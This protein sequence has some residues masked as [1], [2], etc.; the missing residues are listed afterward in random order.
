MKKRLLSG[1]LA[2]T[3]C[4]SMT[5][6]IAW[7]S[8]M[9]EF[10]DGG[11]SGESEKKEEF[12]DEP[13]IEEEKEQPATTAGVPEVENGFSDGILDAAQDTSA[14]TKHTVKIDTSP[15][16]KIGTDTIYDV[17]NNHD[18]TLTVGEDPEIIA[19]SGELSKG[20]S[21]KYKSQN[22]I[23]PYAQYHSK[24]PESN[25][26]RYYGINKLN[27]IPK[28]RKINITNIYTLFCVV[29]GHL[30]GDILANY[31]GVENP[32][33]VNYGLQGG[34]GGPNRDWVWNG[35]GQWNTDHNIEPTKAGYKF[36]GW[37]T[38]ANGNG[39]KIE[40]VSQAVNAAVAGSN[41]YKEITLYAKWVH[42]HA[43]NYSLSGDTLK[44]Y[45]SNTTS[46][47]DYYGT[48]FDNAKATVS[49]KLNGFD[50]NNCA[51]YGNSYSVTCAN[52]LP[53]EIGAT[54]GSII[55]AGR[56]GTTFSESETLPTSPGKYKAKVNITLPGEQYSGEISTDFEIKK[57]PV[58][59]T[60]FLDDFTYG[61]QPAIQI[62][63]APSDSKVVYQYKVK[64]EDDSTYAGITEE[65]LKKLSAGE[66]TL[67]AVVEET[68]NY[69]GDSDTCIFKVKKAST[70]NSD[71]K[72][73]ISGWT[74]GGYNGVENTPSI[75]S[76]L[77][78][79]NQT[80]QYTYYTD[81]ACSTQTSTKNGAETEGGV[82][83]NAGTY[84]V[85]A[86]IPESA[87]YN[88][89]TATGTFE[90]KP[91]PAQLDWSSSD[92]TYNG[93]DQTVTARVRNALPGDTF[94]LTYE[95]NET[96][97]NTGKNARKYTAKVT[98]LGNTNYSLS[99]EES[100]YSWEIK[101]ASTTN[102]ASKVSINGWTYGGYN[103]A[104]NTPSID[105]SLNPENQTVQ[106]TYYTDGACSTQTS[107]KNGAETEGGVPKN[108]GTYYVKAQIPESANYN[109]GTAT[110]TFEI[111]PLP[112]QLDWSSSD[113]TYNGK[114][115]TVTA[116]VRNALPGDTF[117]LTYETNETYTNTGKNARKYT[118][119]V[120]AL[121]N[122]N[123][124]LSQEESI[125]PWVINPKAVTVKPDDLHKHIGGE[126]P[127]LTYTTDGIV[128][129]ETLSGITL[130]RVSGEDARKY[131]ITATE[132]AGAN[133]NYTV[134]REKGT[135]TIE[136]HNWPKDG[137]ILSPATSWSEGMQERTCTAPGCG[138]KRYDSIPKQDGKPADPYADKIDKYIQIFGSEITA[139]ALDNE[140]TILFGLFPGSD[141]TRIDNGS[142]AKVWLEINHVNNLDPA[143]QNLINMEIEKTV[144][145]NAD[146][147]LFDIDLYR[148]LAGE[149][150]VLI[151][152]PG[153]NMNI[154]IKI[155]DKMIN[156]QPYTIRDYKI[157]RLHKDSAT[158]QATV[159]ILDSVFNSSTNELTF[160][161]D[162]FS[163]YVLTYKDTYY[164][165][166]YPVTGIK[167]S[168]DTLTL[169]KKDETAQLTAEVT[170]SYADNKRVT[171]QSS[172]EKVATVDENGKVTAVGNGTA[173][174]TATSVSGSYTATVSVTVKIP[175]EIQK[176][177]I[178]A[179]K[180]T[181]TKIGESTELKVKIEPENA[182]LQKLIWK[183][184]NEKVATTDE[185]GKVTAVGNGTAE[186][187]VT[188][189]D[190]KIT[191]SIM[192]TVKVPD[193]PTINKTTGFRRLRARSVKQTKTSVTLQWNI[194]KDAD[195]YFIYGNRCNTGTK[196]YK[197]RKLATI[198]GGDIST[199]TQKD[200]KKGTYYKYVVKAY[201]L[202]NG[203]KVV[204]DT[205]ISVHAV[206]GGGKYGNA[207][208]VSV[209]QIGNKRNVSKITLKMGKTAQIKAKEV[210]KDKKI[211][212]HRKLCYESSNTKVAT[213]TPDGLIRATGKGTCTIWVYAQNG[214][215]KALKITVK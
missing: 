208:A 168:P 197:Y 203:K 66:Y 32:I 64:D 215:Y 182:D 92:L 18:G 149:N 166:S 28:E 198:T 67:K 85:K 22:N 176:L 178:E 199:W 49:L 194:I 78:P 214:I 132:T 160:K 183:S 186:I 179:E 114:D 167:V 38:Q 7:G 57:A 124:S 90:I 19:S 136:D 188:T 164:S 48:G 37:Y 53:S 143:W 70:T 50:N 71:S 117:T 195:G 73:S 76:S 191:A 60:V 86:Q 87:N 96:Y 107:T 162:K 5:P 74:Y 11:A 29:S 42:K 184:D 135:F 1:I 88:A 147:I 120:T 159:D 210:K 95:T 27:D 204:T 62:W 94:T 193:E 100:V 125:H 134:T 139:A 26:E 98:A 116:R 177:T 137:K 153:I 104:K 151:T 75:D 158:N 36:A 34:S 130:Q 121:G 207:K 97:T 212:R 102:S 84:Y 106:Y 4:F 35:D 189:E 187:T 81:G 133:P 192:I 165:P 68:A 23:M 72:V 63:A 152:N 82:P 25:D 56:D 41:N 65:G 12:T 2:L 145:K 20:Y 69:E 47:C 77:N 111:K 141:K 83:K 206:T 155:P 14:T 129:G 163:I 80:V 105:P 109:A 6:S 45:C 156:N 209:T 55:Y 146:Q 9:T 103:G 173:T 119:K 122:A 101:K 110:G 202:V 142:G 112:A 150:R 118:A 205:S 154:R 175:V 140:E 180:E 91:L 115:Q 201:R 170:P 161:S 200:L 59:L 8:G 196:S 17:I 93:K 113:L 43:W 174:I 44:A 61:E 33:R 52:S 30:G 211:E 99:E 131:E 128:E 171:W 89:G 31:Q 148:Q 172:D 144:G 58:T 126:E 15:S 108:A 181:L 10:S 127:Q 24:N 40:G 54:I 51:E 3:M 185:N 213:V 190:G 123:Y 16:Y 46:Q 157:L 138:Q 21:I 39:S 79:E 169:T 13:E